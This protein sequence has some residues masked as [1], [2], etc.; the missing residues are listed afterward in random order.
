MKICVENEYNRGSETFQY[1]DNTH[2]SKNFYNNRRAKPCFGCPLID[3]KMVEKSTKE[4]FFSSFSHIEKLYEIEKYRSEKSGYKLDEKVLHPHVMEKTV[5]LADSVIHECTIDALAY[6][7]E[8]GCEH[9]KD[10]AA[11]AKVISEWFN[12]DNATSTDYGTRKRDEKRRTNRQET[13]NEGFTYITSF[14]VLYECW[15]GSGLPGLSKPTFGAGRTCRATISLV[16]CLCDLCDFSE[17][18]FG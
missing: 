10:L 12:I 2:L 9:F 13:I 14:V 16:Q 15:K 11:Y 17:R 3:S 8:Y 6:H 7:A 1:F 18:R 4:T 5:K